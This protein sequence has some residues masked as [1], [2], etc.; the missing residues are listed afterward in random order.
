VVVLLVGAGIVAVRNFYLPSSPGQPQ[1]VA[2]TIPPAGVPSKETPALAL[3][4]KPS[5]AVLPFVNL[6]GD[7]EQEYFTDGITEDLITDLSRLSDLFV[8]AR[9]PDHLGARLS[10]T[11]IYGELGREEEARAE[12]AEVLRRIPNFSLEVQMQR[13]PYKDPAVLERVLAALR[14][15]GLK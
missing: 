14:K 9:N 5:I 11:T 1:G 12:A 3:P 15:A 6:S 13:V 2:P 7:P 4:D 8:I 10:L